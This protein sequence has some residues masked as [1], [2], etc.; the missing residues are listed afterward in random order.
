[1]CYHY[2]PCYCCWWWC[3]CWENQLQG[4]C[5]ELN[6][7]S[8][9][10]VAPITAGVNCW[11]TVVNQIKRLFLTNF[12]L[13]LSTIAWNYFF[14]SRPRMLSFSKFP[15]LLEAEDHA[16][17]FVQTRCTWQNWGILHM[18]TWAGSKFDP[19]KSPCPFPHPNWHSS[20]K[21]DPKIHG[22]WGNSQS[23][24]QIMTHSLQPNQNSIFDKTWPQIPSISQHWGICLSANF[25]S[26][27]WVWRTLKM[28]GNFGGW[29]STPDLGDE[30]ELYPQF[31]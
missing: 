7:T 14:W 22:I 11:S 15:A 30:N 19:P 21:L 18:S 8:Y 4:R 20:P 23:V 27:S 26:C 6:P 9:I 31:P 5:T 12:P 13:W 29:S 2:Y 16:S 10:E 17:T 24:R 25:S 3:W 1:M 28:G